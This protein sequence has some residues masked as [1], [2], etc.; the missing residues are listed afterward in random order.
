MFGYTGEEKIAGN[1]RSYLTV[2]CKK[3]QAVLAKSCSL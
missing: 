1:C 3:L 2:C